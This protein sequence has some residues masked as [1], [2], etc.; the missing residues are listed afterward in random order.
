MM[1][2]E[3][4]PSTWPY[5]RV[6]AHRLCGSLAPENT[7]AALRRALL[8]RVRAVE[9]DAMLTAD[10]ELILSHDEVLGRVVK[11]QGKISEFSA[12]ELKQ[13]DAG[14]LFSD[15]FAGEHMALLS[16]AIDFCKAH[17]M[18]MNIEIK[19]A[20]G[21]DAETGMA[22]ARAVREKFAGYKGV[23]PLLSSFSPEALAAARGEAPELKRALL[24]EKRP[25]DWKSLAESVGAMAIH[26]EAVLATPEFVK[27]VREAGYQMMVY[28]VDDHSAAE[29]LLRLGVD[30]ICTN[31]P[32]L[33]IEQDG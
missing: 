11:G 25:D 30:A 33:F 9:T 14:S 32:D 10:G 24:L 12:Q 26:P 20:Q 6:I 28:T 4:T 15:D 1:K 2:K 13:L 27:E 18:R 8:L 5:P 29:A 16:E 17:R 3:S 23:I 7:M 19:P 21:H 22:V 31:R